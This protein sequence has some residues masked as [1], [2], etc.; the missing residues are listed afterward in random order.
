MSAHRNGSRKIAFRS[1]VVR[2]ATVPVSNV[3]VA[4]I[5]AQFGHV[6]LTRYNGSVNLHNRSVHPIALR[7]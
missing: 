1:G 7:C 6:Q 3:N 5:T 4:G 2:R